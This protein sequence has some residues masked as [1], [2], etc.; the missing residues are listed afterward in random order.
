MADPLHRPLAGPARH[1][2]RDPPPV[3]ARHRRDAD[4]A[5]PHRHRAA[6]RDRRR[7]ADADRGR[8]LRRRR[9][10]TADGAERP[11]HAVLRDARLTGALPRRVEGGRVPPAAVPRLRRQRRADALRRR[12]VGAVPRRRGLLR[13][14]TT[15]PRERPDK[16]AEMAELWW[17]RGASATRC[18]RS[19]TSPAAS[20]TPA[21]GASATSLR[22]RRPDRPRP[23]A[24][25]LKNRPFDDRRRCSTCRPRATSTARS[26]PT[27]AT[28]AATCCT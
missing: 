15:S 2:G 25:N 12:R 9:C 11:R 16:L 4:A 8:Q 23:L 17:E 22:R 21:T 7:R 3:R 6:G 18:C 26:S 27:A 10:S 5:R 1:R 20:A 28:P 19:T 14:A 13:G 24:P